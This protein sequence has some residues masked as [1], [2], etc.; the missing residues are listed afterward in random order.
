MRYPAAAPAPIEERSLRGFTPPP[1]AG[2]PPLPLPPSRAS[3]P[4]PAMPAG[5]APRA[6]A[7]ASIAPAPA[8]AASAPSGQTVVMQEAIPPFVFQYLLIS[9][10]V[11]ALGLIA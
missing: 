7:P 3:T 11:T 10:I 9:G 2:R 8:P 4:A 5:H 1:A 6:A